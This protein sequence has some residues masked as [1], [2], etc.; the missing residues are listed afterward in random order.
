MFNWPF[1]HRMKK[2]LFKETD[3]LDV[4]V[5]VT[6]QQEDIMPHVNRVCSLSEQPARLIEINPAVSSLSQ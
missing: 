5:F 2:V 6:H 1:W 3:P 4:I